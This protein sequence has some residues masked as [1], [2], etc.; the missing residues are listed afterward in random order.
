MRFK[1]TNIID[2]INKCGNLEQIDKTINRNE[3]DR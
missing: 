1:N 2:L 3:N